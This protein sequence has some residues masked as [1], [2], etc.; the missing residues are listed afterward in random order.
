M[1][2]RAFILLSFCCF[3]HALSS[4][5]PGYL[6]MRHYVLGNTYMSP[7][8]ADA[9]STFN[10]MFSGEFYKVWTRGFTQGFYVQGYTT[11]FGYKSPFTN[12]VGRGRIEGWGA[13]LKFRWNLFYRRGVIAPLGPFQEIEIGYVGYNIFDRY[14][15][16]FTAPDNLE[17]RWLGSNVHLS[18]GLGVG[19]QRVIYKFITFQYGAYARYV[20]NNYFFQRPQSYLHEQ[21]LTRTRGFYRFNL[22]LG[23]GWLIF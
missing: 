16:Y 23:V 17:N 18:A 19:E 22:N 10:F 12:K 11:Q 14:G 3:V 13:G 15:R 4:Q 1:L 6:G 2:I 5:P 21:T 8:L 7:S 20:S 9:N